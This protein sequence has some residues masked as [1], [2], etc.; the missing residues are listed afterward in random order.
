M[1]ESIYIRN[2]FIICLHQQV[3]VARLES[4]YTTVVARSTSLFG[5]YV[6]KKGQSMLNNNHEVII[7]KNNKF[8]GTG[9][10]SEIVKD[11][12]G[13]EMIFYHAISVDKPH[14][15]VLMMDKVQWNNDWPFIEGGSPSLIANK[16]I[17][18]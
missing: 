10:N 13:Q 12:E 2:G 14:G 5:P 3:L 1:K 16:P 15:R 18:N 17:F 8:V 6:D 9:H 4:T 7:N 11:D